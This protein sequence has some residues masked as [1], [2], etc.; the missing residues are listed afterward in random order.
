M[1]IQTRRVDQREAALI[2]GIR[3]RTLEAYRLRG[4]G[5]SY[6]KVGRRCVYDVDDLEAWM[7]SRRRTSTSDPGPQVPK[8]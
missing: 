2:L 4:G 7:A 6:F 8:P 3:P 5:P 1:G